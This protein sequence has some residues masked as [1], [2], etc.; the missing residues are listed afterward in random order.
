MIIVCQKC[1]HLN[2]HNTTMEKFWNQVDKDS[3]YRTEV[4]LAKDCWEWV[5][6]REERAGYGVFCKKS[7]YRVAYEM[8]NGPIPKG[9]HVCHRCDNPRC[10]R[11]DHLFLGS[12]AD[13]V[14]DK[15][16]KGRQTRGTS[17]KTCKLTEE[18]VRSIIAEYATGEVWAHQLGAKYGV[19]ED[20]IRKIIKGESW[21]HLT[22]DSR[23]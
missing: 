21:K 5:G 1:G 9:M 10:I 17:V 22:D 13:N 15:V 12:A 6:F 18:Q 7:A 3:L 20:T 14:A 4:G 23:T 16:S 2:P 19:H 8:A 11:H